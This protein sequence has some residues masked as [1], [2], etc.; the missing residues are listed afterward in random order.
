MCPQDLLLLFSSVDTRSQIFISFYINPKRHC[1]PPPN[2]TSPKSECF[3]QLTVFYSHYQPGVSHDIV[4][5]KSS[6]DLVVLQKVN[7][8][9]AVLSKNSTFSYIP[10]RIENT[11]LHSNLNINVH[12]SIIHT[13]KKKSEKQPNCLSI[14]A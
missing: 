4:D 14:N 11:C 7:H 2:R 9:V 13:S 3:L 6:V 5:L 1:P 10:K 12:S 8:R